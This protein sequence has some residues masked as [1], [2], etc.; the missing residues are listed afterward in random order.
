MGRESGPYGGGMSTKGERR[1][2]KASKARRMGVSGRSLATVY[3]NAIRKN[4]K[5]A[6]RR[7]K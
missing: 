4:L 2:D 5:K 6:G 7:A 3:Q 1:A